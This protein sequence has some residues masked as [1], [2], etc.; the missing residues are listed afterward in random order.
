MVPDFRVAYSIC[1]QA[2]GE[3]L[4]QVEQLPAFL[5]GLSPL[6]CGL[7]SLISGLPALL[8]GLPAFLSGLSP[9]MC[10]LRSLLGQLSFGG[11][12]GFAFPRNQGV[13][14]VTSGY[15]MSQMAVRCGPGAR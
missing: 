10:G 8:S 14:P 3:L 5:S 7:R 1:Q 2:L 15:P 4:Y 12:S 6:L 11:F 9:L 13:A